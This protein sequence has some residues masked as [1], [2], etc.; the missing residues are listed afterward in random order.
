MW[1]NIDLV[2]PTTRGFIYL[3]V[4]KKT[5]KLYIGKKK[6]ISETRVSVAGSTRKKKVV[7]P[8]NWREYYGSC[9]ELTEDITK[10]G[11]HNFDRYILGAYDELHTVNYGEA[12]LQFILQVLDEGGKHEFYNKN[13]K[14]TSMRSP[15]DRNYIERV[16]E[17]IK[18]L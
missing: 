1:Y 18:G 3:I 13:I 17:I 9:K 16:K 8:S 12:E 7:K 11:K 15:V 4:N 6:T 2:K 5:K 14:I 10:I